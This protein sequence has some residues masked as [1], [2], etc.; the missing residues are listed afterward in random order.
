MVGDEYEIR[1]G[2]GERGASAHRDG[3]ICRA[4]YRRIVDAVAEHGYG[5]AFRLQLPDACEF[6]R[7]AATGEELRYSA[8]TSDRRDRGM[9]VSTQDFGLDA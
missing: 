6:L 8:A 7:R 5:L 2:H 4:E 9:T 3:N 1:C